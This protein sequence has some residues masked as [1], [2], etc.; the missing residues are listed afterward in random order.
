MKKLSF[1]NLLF[2]LVVMLFI[3]AFASVP[4][5]L[6]AA[7]S[8]GAGTL[9][10]FMPR[11]SGMLMSGLQK[12]I[13]TDILLEKFYPENSFINEARDMSALVE[14]NKINLA[15]AGASP[16]VL[17]DNTSYP[18]AVSSRTDVPRELALK[19]LDTTS[20]VVRNVE[21][22]ELAYDKMASVVYG[23]KQELLKTACK[24]AAWNYAPL[25]NATNTPVLT[26]SGALSNGK[27]MLQ[28]EDLLKLMVAFN[29]LDFAADGRILVLNPQ[30]EA[31]LIKQ[32]LTLYKSAI[33]AG[34]V[35][36]FKLY[37][38]SATPVFNASTGVKAA[39][40]AAAAGTDAIASFGFHKDEVMKAIGTTEMF[41]KYAD[42]DNKGDV[43]NFQ[44]RF[45]ALPLRS[46][47]IAAIYSPLE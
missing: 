29:N 35:F 16:D 30:H 45:V 8:V 4:L 23:H 32:D 27:R 19:T 26:A 24:L 7:V 22:M 9:L 3:G 25:S 41:A 10:S 12:E 1:K 47:A 5:A 20:T 43:I 6:S 33:V 34:N 17:I 39:Y 46:K 15:E 18:I 14:F 31:D 40:G 36:G 42:P 2:N 11:V 44:M 21:A 37:R 28:F 38:T 13:W